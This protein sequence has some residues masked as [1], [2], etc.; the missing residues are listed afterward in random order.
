MHRHVWRSED[1]PQ[2]EFSPGTLWPLG[3]EPSPS[4]WQQWLLPAD[5]S[6]KFCFLHSDRHHQLVLCCELPRDHRLRIQVCVSFDPEPLTC[7]VEFY[8]EYLMGSQDRDE[9]A[10][11]T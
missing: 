4:A 8:G 5:P 11:V 7:A 6:H 3:I 2:G 10:K 1:T 9:H